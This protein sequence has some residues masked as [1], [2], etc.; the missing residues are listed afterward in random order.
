L[1]KPSADHLKFLQS[2]SERILTVSCND[3]TKRHN[4]LEALKQQLLELL[5]RFHRHAVAYRRFT[6][7]GGL[8][9]FSGSY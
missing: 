2:K 1:H 7:A 9:V 5:L 6:A 4:Y 3:E 8:A